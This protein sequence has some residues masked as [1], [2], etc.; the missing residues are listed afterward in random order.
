MIACETDKARTG[1]ASGE[2]C[3]VGTAHVRPIDGHECVDA[4][5]LSGTAET[6]ASREARDT[7]A[8]SCLRSVAEV[9]AA[10]RSAGDML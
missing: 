2:A 9:A 8:P 7:V 1:P 3:L 6:P 4:A 10:L 5:S